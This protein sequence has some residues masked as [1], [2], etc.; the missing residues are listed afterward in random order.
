MIVYI[1]QLRQHGQLFLW[2]CLCCI[3]CLFTSSCSESDDKVDEYANWKARNEAFFA[4]LEDSLKNAPDQ[5]MKI[6]SYS[7]DQT[8]EG[9]A[10]DYI[11]AKL[12]SEGEGTDSPMYTDSVRVSYQGRL[13]PTASNPQGLVFDGTVYGNYDIRTNATTKFLLSSLVTGWIT[14]L[15]H[16]HRG[17]YWRIYVP[18]DL[19]YG[20]SA[21]S[22]IPAYSVLIFDLTL[23]DFS[24]VGETMNPFSSR[25]DVG[26]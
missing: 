2:G 17:D 6:K 5:W 24:P 25:K 7:L 14:A 16:M 1:R 9:K 8:T 19:G 26:F 21:T 23:V 18:S 13:I 12:I 4:T 22:S 11:Y 10:S 15:Q 20:S 3:C